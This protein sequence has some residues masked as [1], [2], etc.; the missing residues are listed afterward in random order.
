M[1]CKEK[2]KYK[3]PEFDDELIE[4]IMKEDCPSDWGLED[5]DSNCPYAGGCDKCWANE[6]VE[7]KR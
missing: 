4:Q 3:H 1:T 2:L 7:V 5:D 6:A